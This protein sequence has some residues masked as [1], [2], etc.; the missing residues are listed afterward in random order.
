MKSTVLKQYR[1]QVDRTLSAQIPD[2]P[3]EGWIRQVRKALDMSA[4]VLGRRLGVSRAAVSQMERAETEGRITLQQLEKAAS[5]L[6]CRVQYCL[7]PEAPLAELIEQ[8]AQRKAQILVDSV[9]RTMALERQALSRSE[10]AD[11]VRESAQIYAL[12]LPRDF[13][14][15]DVE[16]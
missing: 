14:L 10:L 4:S 2:R 1:K 9:D 3:R 16:E 15:N 6:H 13:W 12:N 11:M 5:A 8:Q 7:V